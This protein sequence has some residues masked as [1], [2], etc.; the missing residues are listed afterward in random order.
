MW[1]NCSECCFSGKALGPYHTI[2]FKAVPVG[3]GVK[4]EMKQLGCLP[5]PP[6]G[7]PRSSG[8]VGPAQTFQQFPPYLP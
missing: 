5:P 4:K 3:G 2:L 8:P 1:C 7:R 6:P